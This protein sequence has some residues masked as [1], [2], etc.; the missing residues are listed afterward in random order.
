MIFLRTIMKD[1]AKKIK[2]K[3]EQPETKKRTS[4]KTAVLLTKR[5]TQ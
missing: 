5:L 1:Y 4:W 2:N 3:K